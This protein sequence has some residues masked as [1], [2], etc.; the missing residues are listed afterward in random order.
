MQNI[1]VWKLFARMPLQSDAKPAFSLT[2]RQVAQPDVAGLG[3]HP[4][5]S[6][7]DGQ[8][9]NHQPTRYRTRRAREKIGTPN[10]KRAGKPTRRFPDCYLVQVSVS[11]A[12]SSAG[13]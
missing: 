5:L 6:D 7:G 8:R 13:A 1:T 3:S 9:K 2:Q 12:G 4:V 10:E 11:T